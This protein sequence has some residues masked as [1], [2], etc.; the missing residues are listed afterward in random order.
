MPSFQ[1]K[2]KKGSMQEMVGFAK[3][4]INAGDGRLRQ[5]TH[6]R[7]RWEASSRDPFLFD[8]WVTCL[9]FVFL[10]KQEDAW[11]KGM[12]IQKRQIQRVLMG[13]FIINSFLFAKQKNIKKFS[14]FLA[15]F[16]IT[17]LTSLLS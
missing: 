1:R 8:K 17:L 12:G 3:R 13:N 15:R 10:K 5:E 11:I 7:R 6:R 9:P 16:K 4:R 14:R 2:Q